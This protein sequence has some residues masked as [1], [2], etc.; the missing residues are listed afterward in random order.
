MND[1]DLR[2][3]VGRDSAFEALVWAIA[4][5]QPNPVALVAAFR[6]NSEIMK[7]HLVNLPLS[8]VYLEAF[9]SARKGV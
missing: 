6:E 3:H 2:A 5:T 1:N 8:E 9:E 7:A 4:R